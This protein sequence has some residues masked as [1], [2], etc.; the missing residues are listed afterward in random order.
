M[1]VVKCSKVSV[2][3]AD[4]IARLNEFVQVDAEVRWRNKCIIYV[5]WIEIVRLIPARLFGLSQLQQALRGNRTVPSRWESEIS[6]N[7]P[8]FPDLT[9]GRYANNVDIDCGLISAHCYPPHHMIG[10]WGSV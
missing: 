8:F 5:S 10:T 9:S 7:S 6:K 4:S 1:V 2:E 3:H